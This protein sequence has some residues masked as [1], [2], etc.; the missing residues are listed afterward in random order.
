MEKKTVKSETGHP[1]AP[2]GGELP[3]WHNLVNSAI[4][5]PVIDPNRTVFTNRTLRFDRINAVGFDLD[6]TLAIYNCSALDSL[7]MRLAIDRLIAHENIPPA[8]FDDLPEPSFARKGL[9]VDIELGN[10]LKVDRYGHVSIAYH[11]KDRLVG[12]EKRAT[13]GDLDVIPHVTHGDRFVQVDSAFAQPEIL[14]YAG[15]APHMKVGE[16]KNLWRRIRHHTDTVHRDGSLKTV[17]MQ[18]PLA[19]LVPE[20]DTLHLLHHLREGGKRVFLLTNSE[21]NYTQAIVQ[22]SLSGCNENW[23]DL[24]DL[25]VVEANKPSFFSS[26]AKKKGHPLNSDKVVEGGN[27]QDL[28][29]RLGCNG[30]EILYVGDHIYSDLISS[31]RRTHW[32]TMLIISE[33]EEE[34]DAHALLP[35]MVQQLKETEDRRTHTE[36]EVQHWKAVEAALNRLEDS[37]HADLVQRFQRQCAR[38]REQAMHALG[39]FIHQR[40]DLRAQI[41]DATNSYW[42]SLFRAGTEL[43][44]YGRQLEDFACTYTSRATNITL[45]PADHYFRSSMDY[46]PHELESM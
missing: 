22:A 11:G 7:A 19:F 1:E 10:V 26:K 40:E 25:V 44:Y 43:T 12:S 24:F 41:S 4:L 16:R 15:V 35:G 39:E 28:E 31:K 6:H 2:R 3:W 45:Y 37:D 38:N 27:I 9:I 36:R 5:G 17:I 14:I 34:L 21:W 20:V 33:L 13:Y 8:L 18:S 23:I 46:L 30:P 29:K 42:G 32:R